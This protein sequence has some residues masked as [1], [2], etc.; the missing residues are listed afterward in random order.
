[1]N[2]LKTILGIAVFSFMMLSVQSCNNSKTENENSETI[3]NSEQIGAY[4]C[5]MHPEITGEKG[6]KCSICGMDLIKTIEEDHS[7]HNH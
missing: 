2:K 7:G 6:E 5:S 4:S 3:E 1:M